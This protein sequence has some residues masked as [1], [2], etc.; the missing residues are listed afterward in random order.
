MECPGEGNPPAVWTGFL[1]CLLSS[2]ES[3]RTGLLLAPLLFTGA[4]LLPAIACHRPILPST[5]GNSRLEDH[6]ASPPL[7][8]GPETFSH[9]ILA[10]IHEAVTWPGLSL[11][12][13]PCPQAEASPS[14]ETSLSSQE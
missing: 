7:C 6:P 14:P 12:S 1:H 3:R 2:T 13:W 4:D 8:H 11:V 9:D 5:K 10:V